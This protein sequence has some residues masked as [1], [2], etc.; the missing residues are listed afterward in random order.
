MAIKNYL[1]TLRSRRN[2]SQAELARRLNKTRQAVN[3]FESA[4]YEPT[5][6]VANQI[7]MVL[8][9]P[10]SA[11]FQ[12]DIESAV[13]LIA[14]FESDRQR[15]DFV[16]ELQN[17]S[18]S[19]RLQTVVLAHEGECPRWDW[20]PRGE[21]TDGAPA[22]AVPCSTK[23][24]FDDMSIWLREHGCD[25]L[26][27]AIGLGG[28]WPYLAF[29]AADVTY[30]REHLS[31][32]APGNGSSQTPALDALVMHPELIGMVI[33]ALV[34]ASEEAETFAAKCIRMGNDEYG[35]HYKNLAKQMMHLRNRLVHERSDLVRWSSDHSLLIEALL[36]AEV[37]AR[38][39]GDMLLAKSY[40][41]TRQRF[42]D[43]ANIDR[44]EARGSAAW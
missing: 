26:D 34:D 31:D 22:I 10:V 40:F 2:I 23:K 39:L 41:E 36:A 25:V 9:V 42:E 24:Q 20:D 37:R 13:A 43:Q 17:V 38:N 32:W 27:C 12:P 44:S 33:R 18:P 3:G 15:Q 19:D 4:T 21:R 8:D 1:K 29:F 5:I 30:A 11:I 35:R 14:Q 28:R 7:A 16:T 6:D